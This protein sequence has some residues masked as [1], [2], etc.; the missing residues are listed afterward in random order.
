MGYS[1]A[2]PGQRSR[3]LATM[4]RLAWMPVQGSSVIVP[5]TPADLPACATTTHR[6]DRY[7]IVLQEDINEF[8]APRAQLAAWVAVTND[9]VIGHVALHRPTSPAVADLLAAAGLAAVRLGVVSRLMV[10]PEGRGHGAG[11]A[12][13]ETATKDA[14]G[15]GLRPV[16][17]VVT[18]YWSATRLY[19]RAGW[20][21]SA[22]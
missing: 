2:V 6:V 13:L 16:L 22:L 21:R 20:S 19:Q 9:V 15:H 14:H 8:L 12:L 17:D 1:D 11:M 4:A 5:R 10:G 7:P 3:V 18:T